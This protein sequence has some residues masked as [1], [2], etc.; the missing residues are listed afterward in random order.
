[1]A[2]TFGFNADPA[3]GI[4][5]T[6]GRF[7]TPRAPVDLAAAAFGQ[8]KDLVNPLS[9]ASVVAA[10]EDGTWRPP[11]LVTSPAPRQTVRPHS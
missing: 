8:G 6:L 10:I 7:T 3:L 5:A 9:Q 1:M 11:Q 2:A 4:P